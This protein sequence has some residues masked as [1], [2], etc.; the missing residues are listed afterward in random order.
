V[1]VVYTGTISELICDYQSLPKLLNMRRRTPGNAGQ[2]DTLLRPGKFQLYSLLYNRLI[3]T[4]SDIRTLFILFLLSFVDAD[5]TTQSKNM[6]LEQRR[7]IFLST[8]K[9]IAQDHYSVARRIL[10]VCWTGIWSDNKV[11]RTL[12]ISL[13]SE[14]TIGHVKFP[15]LQHTIDF[16]VN[17]SSNSMIAYNQLMRMLITYQQIS[18]IISYL[19]SALVLDWNL[20]Q[21]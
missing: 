19:L 5:A 7:D 10:E 15:L 1:F 3:S 16:K 9:G 17:S 2:S 21:G 18:F 12:K 6:F 4:S 13:F 20:L 11:K 8:F 14:F